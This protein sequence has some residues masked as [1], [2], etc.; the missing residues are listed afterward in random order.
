MD[1]P[2]SA[3]AARDLWPDSVGIPD[4]TL[5]LLLDTAWEQCVEYVPAEQVTAAEQPGYVP[6]YRWVTA[7]V[8]HARDVWTAYRADGG[9][10]GFD[11]YA[12]QVRPLS[13]GVRALLRPPRG[14][15][16]VG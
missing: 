1:R 7:N 6:P 3:D 12:V 14:V 9:V 16:M 10:I 8:L 2:A 4:A 11:Q 13:A 5:D 15:P